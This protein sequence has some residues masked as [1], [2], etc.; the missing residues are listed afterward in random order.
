MNRFA[1][2]DSVTARIIDLVR[3]LMPF[4]RTIIGT[5]RRAVAREL[6]EAWPS[7]EQ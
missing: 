6:E 4:G 7:G 3:W 1:Q 2:R 5:P